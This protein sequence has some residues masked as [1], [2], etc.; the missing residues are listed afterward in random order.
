MTNTFKYTKD[1][2]STKSI[3]IDS[4]F[5]PNYKR[6][7]STDYLYTLPKSINKVVAMKIAAI[8][9]PNMW[10]TISEEDHT[11]EFNIH[12]YNFKERTTNS[13]GFTEFIT[14][15][16]R[17]HTIKLPNGNYVASTSDTS[18]QN[19]I[20]G[21]FYNQRQGL[22]YLY[23]DIDL[24]STRCIFR[25]RDKSDSGTLNPSPYDSLNTSYYS[26]EFYFELDFVLDSDRLRPLHRNIGWLLGFKKDF[27]TVNYD[28]IRSQNLIKNISPVTYHSYLQSESSYG[29]SIYQY[30]FLDI[31]DFHKNFNTDM[32]TSSVGPSYIG[33]NILSRIT[34]S[35][36]ST[37]NVLN[38]AA[39][40]IFRTREYFGPVK[41]E[42]LHIRLLTKFG[43]VINLNG[44]DFSLLIEFTVLNV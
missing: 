30:I 31:D 17:K 15:P 38:N 26:P 9:I 21:Y 8:E 27:Y 42:K 14:I 22:E 34:V 44:N 28:N 5:R 32:I 24:N 35:S 1:Q 41:I 18:I 10:Y 39:D 16:Y 20:N 4:L 11:N 23:F 6:T 37:S 19:A 13:E 7:L 2:V 12:L 33:N 29:S 43:D 36:V 25:A 3:S 40:L